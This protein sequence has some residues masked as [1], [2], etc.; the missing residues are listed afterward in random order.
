[1]RWAPALPPAGQSA[2]GPFPIRVLVNLAYCRQDA[3]EASGPAT[4]GLA[5]AYFATQRYL[6]EAACQE[7]PLSGTH[8]T[9]PSFRFWPAAAAHRE[10]WGILWRGVLRR[11]RRSNQLLRVKSISSSLSL[12]LPVK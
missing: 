11:S 9:R 3:P 10:A 7:W 6:A 4:C 2:A 8:F 5:P 12:P 1:M